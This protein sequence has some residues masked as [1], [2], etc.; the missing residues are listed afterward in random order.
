M[1][2]AE[3]DA[4]SIIGGILK[5]E[6]QEAN[7]DK[8]GKDKDHPKPADEPTAAFVGGKLDGTAL[9]IFKPQLHRSLLISRD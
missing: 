8:S 9:S 1:K 2:N 7:K 4:N 3:D 5:Q 6:K